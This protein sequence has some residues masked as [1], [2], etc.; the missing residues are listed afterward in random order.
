MLPFAVIVAAESFPTRIR[1]TAHGISAAAGK[2]GAILSSLVFNQLKA[3]IGTS[4]VLWIFFATS[5]AG[6]V[7]TLLLD[8]TMGVDPDEKDEAERRAKGEL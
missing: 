4:N 5:M 6:A 3:S 8:E 7:V 2:C 1:A